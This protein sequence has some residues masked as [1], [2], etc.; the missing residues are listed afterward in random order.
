M[1]T[2]WKKRQNQGYIFW[3][4]VFLTIELGRAGNDFILNF[5]HSTV[6]YWK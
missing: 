3:I 4:P 5:D 2:N 1:D 6:K